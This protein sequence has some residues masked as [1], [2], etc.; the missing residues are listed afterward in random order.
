MKRTRCGENR[1][2]EWDPATLQCQRC[3]KRREARLGPVATLQCVKVHGSGRSVPWETAQRHVEAGRAVWMGNELVMATP[4]PQVPHEVTW[5][6]ERSGGIE[7][8][9][10]MVNQVS[11]AWR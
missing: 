10:R 6:T 2:H 3:G 11:G 9:G 7:M 8:S 1:R 5:W 4:M